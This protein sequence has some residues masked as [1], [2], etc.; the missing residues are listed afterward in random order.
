MAVSLKPLARLIEDCVRPAAAGVFIGLPTLVVLEKFDL[1]PRSTGATIPM[2]V[3]CALTLLVT[4]YRRFGLRLAL[5]R[6][7]ALALLGAI[8]FLG[9]AGALW[10]FAFGGPL[11][12]AAAC[13]GAIGLIWLLHRAFGQLIDWSEK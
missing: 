4:E 6:L 3:G 1:M 13:V 11:V 9:A 8:I 5:L 12:A 10:G 7:L 2:L